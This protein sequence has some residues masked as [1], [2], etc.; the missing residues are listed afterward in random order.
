[1]D[2]RRKLS[3]P[4]VAAMALA[5]APAFAADV[6]VYS[7]PSTYYYV[8]AERTYYYVPAERTYYYAPDPAPAQPV[9]TPPLTYYYEQPVTTRI[10][11]ARR[12]EV[13]APRYR[14]DDARITDDV[15]DVL[16]TN[17]RLSGNIGVYT[18][19]RTVH[20]TGRVTTPGQADLASR[21]AMS[22]DGVREVRNE[23]RTRVGGSR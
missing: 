4:L 13:E 19:D 23:L 20:L 22:V 8:P 10:V 7:S 5:I 9:Q 14:N 17:P 15:V 6:V 16:A 12:V 2:A 18:D 3:V 11:E 1:M 21:D